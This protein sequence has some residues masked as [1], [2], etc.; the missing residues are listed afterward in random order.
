MGKLHLYTDSLFDTLRDRQDDLADCA[1][2]SLIKH[3]DWI[4]LINSWQTIPDDSPSD[5]DTDLVRFFE[6]YKQK[7][8]STEPGTLKNGQRFF[9]ENG[10]LYTAMLGL[11]S[12]PYCYAFADGAEV[13][14][15]SKRIIDSIGER[16]GETGSFV[17]EI[18]KPGAFTSERSAF[19]VCAKVRL[20][21]AFSRYFISHYA[22]DWDNAY[23]K[24][25]NQEDMLGTN[26][27]FSQI[28][29]RGLLKLGIS[30]TEAQHQAILAYWKWI[31][32]L[33][34]IDVN[35][36]PETSKEAFELDKLIRKRHIRASE[37]GQKLIGAL[38]NYYRKTIPDP[39][40]IDQIEGIVAF[41]LGK[42]A[43]KALNLTSNRLIQGDLLGLVLKLNGQKNRR[44]KN[45]Y[46]NLKRNLDQQ[47]I[48]QFG[49][50]MIIKLPEIARS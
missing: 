2:L 18:F 46:V 39:I 45:T 15:R 19:L 26:L 5:F 40:L 49:R 48:Q 9:A 30:L 50:L 47:Q 12:L 33:I 13:L 14:V 8:T 32:E 43:S 38:L 10:Q 35:I 16:L 22:K 1:V 3:P 21:H 20:I 7:E 42:D 44:T 27:A 24:P 31:G 23:G 17:M 25:V 11:Y 34:G 28:V 6:F 4:K 41:F 29:L 36:W 37:A